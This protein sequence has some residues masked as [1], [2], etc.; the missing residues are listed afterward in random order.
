MTTT[1]QQTLSIWRRG[2]QHDFTAIA[3]LADLSRIAVHGRAV[4]ADVVQPLTAHDIAQRAGHR[5]RVH[6][7]AHAT[8]RHQPTNVRLAITP[9]RT[10]ELVTKDGP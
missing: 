5:A 8:K 2:E 6:E 4:A 3:D 10:S 1:T 7:F 9:E